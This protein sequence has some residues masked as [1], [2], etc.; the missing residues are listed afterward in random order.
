MYAPMATSTVNVG[1]R[2]WQAIV[3]YTGLTT[4]HLEALARAR[5]HL[6]DLG[7]DIAEEFYRHVL[8]QPGLA[9][10]IHRHSTVERLRETLVGYVGTLWSGRYD[11]D[12]VAHRVRIGKVHDRIQLPLGAYLGAF[13]QIDQVVTRRLVEVYGTEPEALLEAIAGWRTLTQTD[14]AIVAQAFI[15][16][17]DERLT[18]LLETL[19]AASQQVAAQTTETGESVTA[20]VQAAESG[21]ASIGEAWSAVEHMNEAIVEVGEQAAR[22]AE[23]LKRIDGIVATIGSISDQTKLLSLNARIEAARAG[24]HGRGFAVVAEEVGALAERTAQSLV[25]ISEHNAASADVI[26]G[27][28][29]AIDS[30]TADVGAVR[31]ATNGAHASFE[32]T[33]E[34]VIEV[35]RMIGEIAAGMHSIVDQS[36]FSA[37]G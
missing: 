3:D 30:A 19:S 16:A 8:A 18:T 17:R 20:C 15:D 2:T 14:M 22:L 24:D 32:T 29:T 21:T 5:P 27:V 23:Q 34:Q 37:E 36:T 7:A 28:T 4:G 10:L 26:A 13:V 25:V 31:A 12:V 1:D 9:A 6:E 33:R 35:S 11:R